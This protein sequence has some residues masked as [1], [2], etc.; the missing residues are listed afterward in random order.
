MSHDDAG[1][2]VRGQSTVEYALV[3]VAFLSMILALGVVWR[4]AQSGRLL[5]VAR[6]AASHNAEGGVDLGLLQ[7]L[8]SY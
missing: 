8:T 7:D 1:R 2:R 5:G 6:D 3:L 4:E